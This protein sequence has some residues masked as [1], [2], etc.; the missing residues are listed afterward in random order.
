M[1]E[2]IKRTAAIRQEHGFE[3]LFEIGRIVIEAF[4]IALGRISQKP[5]GCTLATPIERGNCKAA[6]RDIVNRLEILFDAFIAAVQ[7]DNRALRGHGA[8]RGDGV[9]EFLAVAKT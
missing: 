6:G 4:H 2:N 8:G 5:A 9:T 7:D 1:R 3:E